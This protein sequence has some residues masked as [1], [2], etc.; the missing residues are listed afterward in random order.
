MGVAILN[1]PVIDVVGTGNGIFS[2]T[3][4]GGHLAL[5]EKEIANVNEAIIFFIHK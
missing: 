5:T 4:G 2:Q 3:H 1:S